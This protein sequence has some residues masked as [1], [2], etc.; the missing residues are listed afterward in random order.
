M[1]TV[2][3]ITIADPPRSWRD[4]GFR[5]EGDTLQV[6]S[7]LIRLAGAGEGRG[8]TG[9]TMREITLEQP[10]RLPITRSP[11][12]H[13]PEPTEP[14]LNSVSKLDHLVAMSADLD[15]TASALEDAGLDLRRVRDEPTPG[16][17]PR[18]AFFRAGEV[19]LELVQRPPRD[20][21]K[22]DRDAPPLFWGLA[23]RVGDLDACASVIGDKLGEPRDAVQPGRRIATLRREA[24][25]GTAVAFMT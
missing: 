24:G 20:D 21:E 17:A 12:E 14:H 6:G 3:T 2:D 22:D 16:G 8:I 5:V 23:F 13:P 1:P 19:I 18:Q 4:A 10:D 25:I 11:S 7:I 9:C 15:R